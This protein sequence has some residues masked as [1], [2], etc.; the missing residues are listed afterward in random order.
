[1]SIGRRI[2]CVTGDE[3]VFPLSAGEQ[4]A[5]ILICDD[6]EDLLALTEYYLLRAGF[7][8]LLARNGKEAVEKALTCR[9]HLI[10]IDINIPGLNGSE[11]ASQLRNAGFRAPILAITGS[12]IGKLDNRNFT[13]TLQKPVRLP[14][15]LAE[16]QAYIS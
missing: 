6:D 5:T 1:M 7:E 16:I 10:L 2:S 4:A 9:P 11:V 14:R 12:D 15:L 13:A 8:L 3:S